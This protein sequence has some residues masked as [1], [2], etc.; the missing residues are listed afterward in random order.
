MNLDIQE[1]A[2]FGFESVLQRSDLPPPSKVAEDFARNQIF[3]DSFAILAGLLARLRA[4]IATDL[5]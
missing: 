1:D 3:S 2:F 5:L 4:G